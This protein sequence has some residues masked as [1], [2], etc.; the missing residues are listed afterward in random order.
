MKKIVKFVTIALATAIATSMVSSCEK[1]PFGNSGEDTEYG[2]Y[3]AG[4]T[5][6]GD[7]LIYKQTLDYGVGSYTQVL[8]FTFEN[9]ICVKAT[10]EFIWPTEI[11]AKVFYDAL[12]EEKANARLSGKKVI[13]DFTDTYKG[14]SKND[15][16]G[17]IDASGGWV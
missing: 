17:A 12:E 13:I 4:W 5:E 9:D 2:E 7:K 1:N 16:K 10:G 8:I 15:L 14:L 3:Q 11:L 6:K